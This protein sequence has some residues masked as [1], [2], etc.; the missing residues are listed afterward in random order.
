MNSARENFIR[1][2]KAQI[3]RVMENKKRRDEGIKKDNQKVEVVLKDALEWA[4]KRS[5]N[6]PEK[7]EKEVQAVIDYY[8]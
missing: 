1:Q 8:K 5:Y 7:A 3:Q 4:N 6:N 2:Q